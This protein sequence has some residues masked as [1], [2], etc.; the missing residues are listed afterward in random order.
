M[1]P[2]FG[3]PDPT[4]VVLS[5]SYVLTSKYVWEYSYRNK[6][7]WCHISIEHLVL[8]KKACGLAKAFTSLRYKTSVKTKVKSQ[9]R[10]CTRIS[11]P[12]FARVSERQLLPL[13]WYAPIKIPL[14]T[15]AYVDMRFFEQKRKKKILL[16]NIDV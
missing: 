4:F 3:K 7:C 12:L 5:Y 11:R 15:V 9:M 14:V 16:A 1:Q 6:S 2:E 8:I 10:Q 13:E